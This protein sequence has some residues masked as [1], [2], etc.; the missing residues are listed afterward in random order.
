MGL[1]FAA[2][3][4][5]ALISSVAMAQDYGLTIGV[6]QTT[7]TVTTGGQ[8]SFPAGSA[9]GKLN[10]DLGLTASFEL[11]PNFRFRFESSIQLS[12]SPSTSAIE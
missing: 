7:A 8:N 4:V 6:H 10:Y 12:G 9:E 5:G 2:I 3:V 11:I 1:K